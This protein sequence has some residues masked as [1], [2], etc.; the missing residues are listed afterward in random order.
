[1]LRFE[2]KAQLGEWR[3]PQCALYAGHFSAWGGGGQ[4][5][6]LTGPAESMHSAKMCL[7][8]LLVHT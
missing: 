8:G 3:Q 2:Q 4:E 1:M 5:Q 7:F 6:S